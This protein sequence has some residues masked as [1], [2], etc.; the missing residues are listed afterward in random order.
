MDL[1]TF[2]TRYYVVKGLEQIKN[3]FLQALFS[4][5]SYSTKGIVNIINSQFYI[6][7]LI[8][9][10][11]R[12]G[13]KQEKLQMVRAFLEDKELIYN[14]RK[15]QHEDIQTATARLLTNIKSRQGRL[16]DKGIELIENVISNKDL[17]VNK[18]LI[19]NVTDLLDKNLT[20]LVANGL[21]KQYKRPVLL[22]RNKD[23]NTLIGSMRGYEKGV[24]KDFKQFLNDTGKFVFVEGHSNAAGCEIKVDKLVEVNE[25]INEQLKDVEIDID[26]HDVDLV[27]PGNQ[28]KEPLFKVLDEHR[29]LWSFKV[30]EPVIAIKDI[31]VD[32][33]DVQIMGK[34]KSTLKFTYRGIEFIKFKSSEEQ[35][36]DIVNRGQ[37]LVFDVVGRLGFNEWE[38]KKTPQIIMEDFEVVKTKSKEWIF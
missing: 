15:K 5:Q 26:V 25:L 31:S 16:R 30:E 38:G 11:I 17:L 22:L 12:S 28:L 27:I 20:G 36:E 9:A 4:K 29:D 33:D 32:K 6:I 21:I 35:Y 7:P 37:T 34:T 8:N 19:V 18:V 3:K 1:R 24:I 13:N 10:C 23:E 2:E 14:S